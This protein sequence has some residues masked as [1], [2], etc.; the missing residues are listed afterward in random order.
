MS[1]R[2]Y[3]HNGYQ[4]SGTK[5]RTPYVPR[6]PM[7]ERVEGAPRGR[8]AGGF[9][10]DIFK[11]NRC[12]VGQPPMAEVT[13]DSICEKCSADLH[14]CSNCKNFDTM[15]RW[16]CRRSEEIPRRMTPKD[17]RN[18]CPIMTPRVVRDLAQDKP[19]LSTP[20]DSRKA[21]DDLFKG[22]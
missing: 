4:D 19:K 15:S 2:K 5:A 11:C 12:G 3:R 18:D 20:D 21:W 8:S 10:P 9:G 17:V 22:K 7:K 6:E 1:D 13:F 14:T 16:E